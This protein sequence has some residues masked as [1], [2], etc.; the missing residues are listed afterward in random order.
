MEKLN[1]KLLEKPWFVL[2]EDFH[3]AFTLRSLYREVGGMDEMVKLSGVLP[4]KELFVT[5]PKGFVTDMASIPEPLQPILHPDGPWAAAA[6]VHDLFYQKCSSVGVYPTGDAGDLS[7]AVDK[8][9]ADIMFLRIMEALGVDPFIRKS[10]Y[11]AV[12]QFG[13]PSYVD[14]NAKVQYSHPVEK[15]LTY[16]RNYLFI[17]EQCEVAI[18]EHERVDLTTGHSVNVK[19]LNIKR[20]FLSLD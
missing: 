16:N 1:Y 10:F 6:C 19:Y 12:H 3:F 4:D 7:R 11:E 8:R 13:W 15:T 20:A 18:P 14:N 17:R 9:F 5:A 2:T